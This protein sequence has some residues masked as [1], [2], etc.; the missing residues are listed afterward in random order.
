M[1][2]LSL[3]RGRV[4][5]RIQAQAPDGLIKGVFALSPAGTLHVSELSGVASMQSLA[6]VLPQE[7]PTSL[8]QGRAQFKL[9]DLRLAEGWPQSA[10][11]QVDLVDLMLTTPVEPLGSYAMEL[12]G[13]DGEPIR[14]SFHD[15]AGALE[16]KG[17]I[18]LNAD[19]TY[20]LQCT[21]RARPQ[22]SD[23]IKASVGLICPKS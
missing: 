17:T 15:T 13:G 19:R 7:L 5:Y 10:H 22:A 8:F 20:V 11:G 21:A 2:P 3:L 9:D 12:D 1:R 16:I 23:N 14:G 6:S 4:A 18:T